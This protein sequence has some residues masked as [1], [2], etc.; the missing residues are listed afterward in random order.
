[1]TDNSQLYGFKLIGEMER[2]ELIEEIAGQQR[3]QLDKMNI[4]QLKSI[5]V[6]YRTTM[7]RHRLVDEAGF[8]DDQPGINYE[9]PSH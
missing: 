4:E 5:V 7:Y 3:N 6:D 2:E 8:N 9:G 1:M